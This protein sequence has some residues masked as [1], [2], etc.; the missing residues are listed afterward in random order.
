LDR[1]DTSPRISFTNPQDAC[2]FNQ[3]KTTIGLYVDDLLITAEDESAINSLL[4]QLVKHFKRI[5]VDVVVSDCFL[6]FHA[7]DP[8]LWDRLSS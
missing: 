4:E 5:E 6:L 2:V 7:M 1:L 8:P 3:G